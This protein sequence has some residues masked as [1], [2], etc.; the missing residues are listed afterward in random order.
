MDV[1]TFIK[2]NR[3]DWRTLEEEMKSLTKKRSSL[4]PQQIDRFQHLY[5]RTARQLSY[6][7]TYFPDEEVTSYLNELTAK[8]HNL[9]YKEETTSFQQLRRFFSETFILLLLEQRRFIGMAFLFFLIGGVGA[10]LSVM[11]DPVHLYSILPQQIAEGIN[12]DKIGPNQGTFDSPTISASIMTNNIKV[13]ILAFA[14]GLTFGVLTVYLLIQNGMILGALAAI[15]LQHHRFYEFWAYIVPH[16]IIELSA[17]F[18]AGGAGL[19][20]GYKILVPGVYP[21]SYQLKRQ[22]LRSVQLMLGT[23]PLFIIAGTIEGFITPSPIPL[24]VKYGVALLTAMALAAYV[25]IGYRLQ[26]KAKSKTV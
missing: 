5:E 2:Q 15:F 14:G 20:M 12:P 21:R 17:I 26:R 18:I 6:S 24:D 16:G 11:N 10:F 1:K 9:F 25:L 4:S 22:A 23:V 3:M 8:A 7:Q 19:L 13:A